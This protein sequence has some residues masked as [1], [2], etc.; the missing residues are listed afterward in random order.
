MVAPTSR[1]QYRGAPPALKT[2]QN[3]PSLPAAARTCHCPTH[4]RSTH[5][6]S[7]TKRPENPPLTAN[8]ARVQTH[9][10]PPPAHLEQLLVSDEAR[11][12]PLLVRA[13][14]KLLGVVPSRRRLADGGRRLARACLYGG[15]RVRQNGQSIRGTRLL[16]CT[17]CYGF[18]DLARGRCPTTVAALPDTSG[19]RLQPP[20]CITMPHTCNKQSQ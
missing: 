16:H 19:L 9:I 13:R 4:V 18:A 17:R 1:G 2:T 5:M 12:R 10:Q 8:P 3:L 6:L 15:A 14:A 20:C 7:D 11:R